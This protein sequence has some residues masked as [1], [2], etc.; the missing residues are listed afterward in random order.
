MFKKNCIYFEEEPNVIG[1]KAVIA[2]TLKD[3]KRRVEGYCKPEKIVA[4][5]KERGFVTEHKQYAQFCYID[6]DYEAEYEAEK[7]LFDVCRYTCDVLE[8][9]VKQVA[10][11]IYQSYDNTKT[12][13]LFSGRWYV[14]ND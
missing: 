10:P 4:Y 6:S 13:I 14:L 2:D 7:R 9:D 1:R 11:G 12:V 8:F 3:L 5:D